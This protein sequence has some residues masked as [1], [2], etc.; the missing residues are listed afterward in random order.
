MRRRE[1]IRDLQPPLRSRSRR[2]RSD[3]PVIGFVSGLASPQ[4]RTLWRALHGELAETAYVEGS[5][6]VYRWID[7][8][9]RQRALA[10]DFVGRRAAG[11]APSDQQETSVHDP[12]AQRLDVA[13]GAAQ[14]DRFPA[15]RS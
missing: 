6:I 5:E 1:F 4:R 3:L 9:A 8:P 10:T 2:G 7:A 11:T 13:G 14:K 12:G 15:F